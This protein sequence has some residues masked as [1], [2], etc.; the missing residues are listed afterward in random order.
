M[1]YTE[2]FIRLNCSLMSDYK[3]MKLNAEMKCMG[4]G[5][6]IQM[7]LFLR[8]QQ[9]YKHDFNELDLLAEQWGATVEDLQHLIKDFNLFVIMEDGYF[10]CLYLDEVMGYQNK[11]SEQRAAAGSKGGRSS[12]KKTVQTAEKVITSTVLTAADKEANDDAGNKENNTESNAENSVKCMKNTIEKSDD[13]NVTENTLQCID[14]ECVNGDLQASFKQNFIRE[15]KNRE[16][17]KNNNNKEKEII[18]VAAVDKL[19]RFS[20][21]SETIPRWEQCINEA[22]I[23]QSWLEAVGMMSGL[24][25]LFLNNLSFIRDLFKKHVVAQGNTGGIT[26]VSEAEAYFANY[27]C[28]ERPTRLFLEEKLKERS[29]MQNESISLSPYETYN[30]LTGERSYCGVPLPAD[31]PPRPNGRATWDNLK[32]SWI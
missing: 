6:Y 16:E 29:R 32:Q 2:Q 8:R 20:E 3:M 22:F 21:L 15:E 14:N 7:I 13:E 31:A 5:L 30:P 4:I 19:P 28:R 12:K 1:D 27:I 18:A 25:E 17:K 26:S 23:T 11:L 10:R 24:K 9:E